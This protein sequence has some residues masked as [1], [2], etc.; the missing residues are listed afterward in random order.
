MRISSRIVQSVIA[1]LAIALVVPASAQPRGRPPAHAPAHGLRAKQ[2]PQITYVSRAGNVWELDYGIKSGNC[3]RRAIATAL[4][5][6]AGALIA[7][8]VADDDNRTVATLIGAAAGALIGNRIGRNIDKAD[9]ACIGHALELGEAGQPVSWTNEDTGVRYQVV[10][11][12]AR[13]REGSTC[14]EFTFTAV[15]ESERSTRQGLGCES[16]PGVWQ[17]VQ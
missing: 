6:I 11:G 17:I 8:R 3:D 16:K 4:G 9:E 12:A 2:Q 7:N 1:A 13:D 14:R 10:P 15:A 5:G